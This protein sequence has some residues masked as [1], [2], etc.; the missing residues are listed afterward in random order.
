MDAASAS[1]ARASALTH[2]LLAFSRR[3][4]LDPKPVEIEG[5]IRSISDLIERAIDE[6]IDFKIA[7][8]GDLPAAMADPHQLESAILNLALNAR[9][10]MPD[11][12]SLT[13]EASVAVFDDAQVATRP[14]L[15]PGRYLMV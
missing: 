5:L 10:A 4:S 1:A 2:R 13:I 12:G 3:Q 14:G 8:K 6:K 9:D 7:L 11:G 15:S